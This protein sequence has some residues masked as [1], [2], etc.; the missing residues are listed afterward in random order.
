MDWTS[1]EGIAELERL[2]RALVDVMAR[3]LHAGDAF[4]KRDQAYIEAA[5]A[6]AAEVER[7]RAEND[8][9]WEQIRSRPPLCCAGSTA[10]MLEWEGRAARLRADLAEAR[11]R[12]AIWSGEGVPSGWE[13]AADGEPYLVRRRGAWAVTLDPHR[14]DTRVSWVGW[15]RLGTEDGG[16]VLR[17]GQA[18]ATEA[19]AAA[20]AWL[21]AVAP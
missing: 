10:L 12:L 8:R 15:H 20:E 6:L 1:P 11:L 5:P 17:V 4:H 2:D 7:L 9:L 13:A 19:L 16:A 3:R 14:G 21:A 18:T